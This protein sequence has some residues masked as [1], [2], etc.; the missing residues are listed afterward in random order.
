MGFHIQCEMGLVK[1]IT[2]LK[3]A[4]TIAQMSKTHKLFVHKNT[5]EYNA[6]V[7]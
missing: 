4:Y 2:L 7:R 1:T 6:T 3:L 5:I